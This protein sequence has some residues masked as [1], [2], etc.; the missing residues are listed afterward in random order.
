LAAGFSALAGSS[1]LPQDP[2][3][4]NAKQPITKNKTNRFIRIP[5]YFFIKVKLSGRRTCDPKLLK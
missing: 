1:F 5:P 4:N 3:R 2:T